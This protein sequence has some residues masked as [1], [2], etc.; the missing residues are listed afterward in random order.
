MT[1]ATYRVLVVDDD[2]DTRRILSMLFETNG[3]RVAVADSCELGIRQAQTHR[4]DVCMVSLG[5]PDNDGLHF[6]RRIRM[7]S[8]VAI[9]VLGA[10]VEAQQL[11]AF[12]AGADDYV[13]KP[14]SSPI[15]LARVRAI[16]RRLTR[17]D[18]PEGVLRLGDA[19][20][21]LANRVTRGP[22]GE[23]VHLTQLEHRII[24]CL[25]RHADSVV[26]H[27]QLLKEV[28]GPHQ[29]D[30]RSL[31]VFVAS[32]RRK[33]ELD[34]AQPK[35]IMTAPGVGY[36]LVTEPSLSRDRLITFDLTSVAAR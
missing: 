12:E 27:M 17:N 1:L 24:E 32:L 3:F 25:A 26:T 34:G 5:L 30:I 35:Y 6:I 36:R 23:D 9:V 31:R 18:Q 19:C 22:R 16:M 15:L 11:S 14:F 28:W 29:S 8:P 4:P 7:W 13:V 21:D 20:I 2:P 33:L 10:R